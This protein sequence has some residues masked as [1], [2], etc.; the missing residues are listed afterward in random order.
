MRACLRAA[1]SSMRILGMP[2]SMALAMP[3]SALDLFNQ[4][5]GGV[6]ELV[7]KALDI[8]GA[9]PGIDDAGD[10]GFLLKINLGVAGDAR[11]ELGG[12]GEGF[13]EGVG[14]ERL[15]VAEGGGE[16]LN[17][18][19]GNVVIWVLRCQAPARCLRM[20]AQCQRFRIFRD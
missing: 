3:P 2:V 19:A 20:C 4:L 1:A 17:A 16:R 14:V 18:G 12:Q 6:H 10:A 7:R 8:I 13:I 15:G 11:G 9:G 5:P